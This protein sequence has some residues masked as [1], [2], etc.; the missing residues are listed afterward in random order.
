NKTLENRAEKLFQYQSDKYV[1]IK[2]IPKGIDNREWEQV[3]EQILIVPNGSS[4]N[5]KANMKR[6]VQVVTGSSGPSA[7]LYSKKT[8]TSF[9]F[10]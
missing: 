8:N 6:T 1:K 5:L 10:K 3:K 7:S 2:N 9:L 4:K